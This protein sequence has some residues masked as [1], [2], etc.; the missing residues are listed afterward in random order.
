MPHS[1]QG[2]DEDETARQ[3]L[4]ETAELGELANL[5]GRMNGSPD[6]GRA[7]GSR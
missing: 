4:E 1:A 7:A 6:N 5:G 3:I 2:V